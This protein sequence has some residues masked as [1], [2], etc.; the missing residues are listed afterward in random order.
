M[1]LRQ[2]EK[3]RK[4]LNFKFAR[5]PS[6]NLPEKHLAAIETHLRKRASQLIDLSKMR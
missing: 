2:A 4:M 3:L 1:T 6:L 5:H